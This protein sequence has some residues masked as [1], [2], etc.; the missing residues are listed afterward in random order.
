MFPVL[1]TKQIPANSAGV[2]SKVSFCLLIPAMLFT[3][4]SR[5]SG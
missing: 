2:L 3:K 4:V 1:Q 5:C